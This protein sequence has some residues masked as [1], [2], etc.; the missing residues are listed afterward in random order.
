MDDIIVINLKNEAIVADKSIF[1]EMERNE[2]TRIV[3]F[4]VDWLQDG[5][6][7][8]QIK[9]HRGDYDQLVRNFFIKDNFCKW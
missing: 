3:K 2:E 7:L 8:S 6:S 5:S 1:F 9:I 4:P